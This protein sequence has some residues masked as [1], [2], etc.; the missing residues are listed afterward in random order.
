METAQ[1]TIVE[2]ENALRALKQNWMRTLSL[3]KKKQMAAARSQSR[4]RSPVLT[5]P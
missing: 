1:T 4:S 3:Q 2:A 5:D